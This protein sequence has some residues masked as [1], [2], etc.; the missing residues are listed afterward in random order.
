MAARFT[1][2]IP[3]SDAGAGLAVGKIFGQKRGA[4][5]FYGCLNDH[6]VP[7]RQAVL[8]QE[9]WLSVSA[10]WQRYGEILFLHRARL[11]PFFVIT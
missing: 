9:P 5:A 1:K 2:G 4:V 6:G 7:E 8:R 3:Y 11:R 10:S